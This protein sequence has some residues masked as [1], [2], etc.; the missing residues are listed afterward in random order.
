MRLIMLTLFAFSLLANVGCLDNR[1]GSRYTERRVIKNNS[2]QIIILRLFANGNTDESN[3]TQGDSVIFS[4][5]CEVR[6]GFTHCVNPGTGLGVFLASEDST[7][8]IF[9]DE[10]ILRYIREEIGSCCTRNILNLESQWGYDV[11]GKGTSLITY[12]Y[13]ITNEDYKSAKDCG[14]DC[15]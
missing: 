9:N 5:E 12:T 14:G 3:I 4:A 13:E 2:G 1:V 8:I 11:K 15:D 6:G 7:H 10:K